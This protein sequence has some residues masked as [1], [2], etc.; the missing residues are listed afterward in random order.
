MTERLPVAIQKN[1]REEI[2]ISRD[3]FRGHDL[4]SIRIWFKAN[5][6]SMRPTKDGVAF[7]VA[8]LDQIIEALQAAKAE[9]GK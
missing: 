5:D 7:R 1:S 3:I 4:I 9:G 8:L 6:G 2:R